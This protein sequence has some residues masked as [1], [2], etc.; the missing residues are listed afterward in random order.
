MY[1][2][3]PGSGKTGLKLNVLEQTYN[4]NFVT[5]ADLEVFRRLLGSVVAHNNGG[6]PVSTSQSQLSEASSSKPQTPIPIAT[7]YR[8]SPTPYSP[9]SVSN[10]GKKSG[11]FG[12]EI[13]SRV[14]IK[15]HELAELHRILVEGKQ[16]T[17][18]EFWE[19]REVRASFRKS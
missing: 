12:P 2:S 14:L 5:T 18:H 17:E 1:A 10:S 6:A 8:S 9:G 4:F 13:Y 7:P 16:I 11:R 15:H 19:G 3:K